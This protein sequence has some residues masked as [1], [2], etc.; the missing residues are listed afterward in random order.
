[1]KKGIVSG[2]DTTNESVTST[3][4]CG[5][6]EMDKLSEITSST[7]TYVTKRKGR[8]WKKD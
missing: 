3:S 6:Q 8:I 4:K 7:R 5:R 1:M 2:D